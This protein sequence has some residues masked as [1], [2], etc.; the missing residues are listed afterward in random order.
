MHVDRTLVVL[1]RHR[2][3]RHLRED[4]FNAACLG[5]VAVDFGKQTG[6]ILPVARREAGNLSTL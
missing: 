1:D 3:L 2:A 5:R 4:R 6:K